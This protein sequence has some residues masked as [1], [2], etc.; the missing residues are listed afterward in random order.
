MQK[1]IPDGIFNL[2]SF[3]LLIELPKCC[4]VWPNLSTTL[5]FKKK[6]TFFLP[7]IVIITWPLSRGQCYDHNFRRFLPI[8]GEK[9]VFFMKTN[10]MIQFL[11]NLAFVLSKKRHFFAKF[12]GKNIFKIITSVPDQQVNPFFSVWWL[13]LDGSESGW[14]P[15]TDPEAGEVCRLRQ[16]FQQVE[17]VFLKKR[18]RASVTGLVEISRKFAPFGQN[19]V[20]LIVDTLHSVRSKNS[21][22]A[23]T[24]FTVS[25]CALWKLILP[26]LP[27]Y[28]T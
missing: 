3:L 1:S 18:C 17:H 24:V 21:Q 23:V 15:A 12:F 4:F 5:V 22:T 27:K 11:H 14:S 2:A 6:T 20:T 10:V 26:S 16:H 13:W 9:M 19:P 8:F 28:L 25:K 7:K